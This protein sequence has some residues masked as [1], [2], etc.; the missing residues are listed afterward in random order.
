M[1]N[2]PCYN[3]EKRTDSCHASCEEYQTW[4]KARAETL[5]K[6]FEGRQRDW[7]IYGYNLDKRERL[8]R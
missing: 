1:P 5:E 6:R 2:I 3:C 7:D 8:K 4:A